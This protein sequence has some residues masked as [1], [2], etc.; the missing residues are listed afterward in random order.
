MYD[1][2]YLEGDDS[3]RIICVA[4]QVMSLVWMMEIMRQAGLHLNKCHFRGDLRTAVEAVQSTP[5]AIKLIIVELSMLMDYANERQQDLSCFSKQIKTITD[6]VV[7]RP[8]EPRLDPIFILAS[9]LSWPEAM[10]QF[11]E[12]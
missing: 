10:A 1:S 6:A 4:N 5:R 9:K 8:D 2:A 3:W 12:A 11:R 7:L